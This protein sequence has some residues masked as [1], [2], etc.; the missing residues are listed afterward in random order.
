MA[1]AI[2]PDTLL[3]NK[4]PISRVC[5][6]TKTVVR[7]YHGFCG[8]AKGSGRIRRVY[9]TT[10][11]HLAEYPFSPF[12]D[13]GDAREAGL[14]AGVFYGPQGLWGDLLIRTTFTVDLKPGK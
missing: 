5:R 8:S 6:G 9:K 11:P 14:N 4:I 13:E 3:G 12:E 1:R 2:N 7:V 10:F